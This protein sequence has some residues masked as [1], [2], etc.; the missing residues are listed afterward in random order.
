ME[1][2]ISQSKT[3]NGWEIYSDFEVRFESSLEASHVLQPKA[4]HEILKALKCGIIP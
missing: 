4:V 2:G 3:G 1:Q